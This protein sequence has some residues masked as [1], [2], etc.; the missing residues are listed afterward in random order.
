[1]L[2]KGGKF[3]VS[4]GTIFNEPVTEDQLLN[5][6]PRDRHPAAGRVICFSS[7]AQ[8]SYKQLPA[9][10]DAT[11]WPKIQISPEHA[12]VTDM[13]RGN[14]AVD[15]AVFDKF[16]VQ[17][18]YPHFTRSEN[19]QDFKTNNSLQ[20]MRRL[21]KSQY[22]NAARS[23]PTHEHLNDITLKF[24]E[25]VAQDTYYP[26]AR[27]NAMLM[28]ADLNESDPNGAPWKKRCRRF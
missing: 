8:Q 21:C 17:E 9:P 19:F 3:G 1:M 16:F 18:V 5:M 10:T 27:T 2:I 24:M 4:F 7:A 13:L 22:F 20:K 12:S 23:G 14:T 6:Q 28:I 26:V 15:N 25:S 11:T